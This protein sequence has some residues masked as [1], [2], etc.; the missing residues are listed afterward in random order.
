MRMGMER[1]KLSFICLLALLIPEPMQAQHDTDHPVRLVLERHTEHLESNS[2][3]TELEEQIS[4]RVDIN[5][6]VPEELLQI[7]GLRLVH[8]LGILMHRQR[9]GPFLNLEELQVLPGFDPALIRSISPWLECRSPD[10][11][12]WYRLKNG[13]GRGKHE[14]LLYGLRSWPISEKR[15]SLPDSAMN[16]FLGD[17]FRSHVRYRYQVP[18]LLTMGWTA[19]KDPGEPWLRSKRLMDFNSFHLFVEHS[20]FLRRLALGDYQYNAAQGLLL[21]TGLGFSQSA[22]VMQVKRNGSGIRPFRSVNE[23][24]YLRG[25]A[26]GLV[27]GAWQAD[28]LVSSRRAGGRV[29]PDSLNTGGPLDFRLD[30]DGLHRSISEIQQGRMALEQIAGLNLSHNSARGRLGAAIR[31]ERHGIDTGRSFAW[32]HAGTS[33]SIYGDRTWRNLHFF[34]EDRRSL[35]SW[36]ESDARVI[37]LLASLHRQFDLSLLHRSYSPNYDAASGSGFGQFSSNETGLYIGLHWRPLP[38]LSIS[39]YQDF[40]RRPFPSYRNSAATQGMSRL[41]ECSYARSRHHVWY[42]RL[43]M[44]EQ[45]RNG[46]SGSQII[47]YPRLETIFH[48]RFHAD[49]ALGKSLE[50]ASR[51]EYSFPSD[52]QFTGSLVFQDIQW[53]PANRVWRL[54]ARLNIFYIPTSNARIFAYENDL[55]QVFS[56]R[57]FQGSGRSMYLLFQRPVNKSLRLFLRFARLRYDGATQADFTFSGLIRFQF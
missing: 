48:L 20:G 10:Q 30:L 45:S 50:L 14:C 28:I 36:Q 42:I 22:L 40:W 7:P 34:F 13:V 4:R 1:Q 9:F 26:L 2:D 16:R 18:G 44:Q 52:K 55:P 57:G 3:L 21:G 32:Q 19:E 49:Y 43:R 25:M 51:L 17:P 24:R 56:V 35:P 53:K 38:R 8:V 15:Y 11:Q 33:F 23:S 5:R 12:L 41:L 37:G 54:G 46:F 6:A 31:S 29:H 47:P 27:K 39:A